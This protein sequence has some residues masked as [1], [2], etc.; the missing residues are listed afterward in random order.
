[1]INEYET[2]SQL[3]PKLW[4]GDTLHPKV[5]IAFLKIAKMAEN[6]GVDFWMSQGNSKHTL[7]AAVDE[8]VPY[9]VQ[10]KLWDGPQIK[11]FDFK[12]G[13]GILLLASS[14]FSCANC[15]TYLGGYYR[16]QNYK[17]L[18]LYSQ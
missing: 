11:P 3:N 7:K 15:E 16:Q 9:L 2:H 10:A 14:K 4:D 8:M 12:E 1:M 18:L 5:R 17:N 6:T 13:V